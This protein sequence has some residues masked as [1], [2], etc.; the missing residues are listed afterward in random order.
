MYIVSSG[1]KPLEITLYPGA[2]IWLDDNQSIAHISAINEQAPLTKAQVS[3][4]ERIKPIT[5]NNI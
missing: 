1:T 3:Y 5:N 2:V 4:L